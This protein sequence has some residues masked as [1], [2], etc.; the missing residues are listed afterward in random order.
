[1]RLDPPSK[2]M[3]FG[4]EFQSC[5]P[6]PFQMKTIS[7]L[8]GITTDHLTISAAYLSKHRSMCPPMGQPMRKYPLND[9][10]SMY[11][12]SVNSASLEN[13]L[14]C[15]DYQA[16]SYIWHGYVHGAESRPT[17]NPAVRGSCQGNLLLTALCATQR[18]PRR[19][20]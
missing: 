7:R 16:L 4:S 14:P 20:P 13:A 6:V 5:S 18:L 17:K 10:G 19:P 8:V 11:S 12:R 1:M 15:E 3:S 9:A 2:G